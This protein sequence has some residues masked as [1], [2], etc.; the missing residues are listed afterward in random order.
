MWFKYSVDE[1]KKKNNKTVQYLL[2][3][4]PDQNP[5]VFKNSIQI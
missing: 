3:T 1:I 5:A 4:I 2:L